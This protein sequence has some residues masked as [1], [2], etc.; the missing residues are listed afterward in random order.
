[1][2]CIMK[3]VLFVHFKENLAVFALLTSS[4]AL[5][6][7]NFVPPSCHILKL[8]VVAFIHFSPLETG[9]AQRFKR[10]GW[11]GWEQGEAVERSCQPCRRKNVSI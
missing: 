3:N 10:A 8:S 5:S 2:K 6:K 1:M 4:N 11:D 9:T 7:L